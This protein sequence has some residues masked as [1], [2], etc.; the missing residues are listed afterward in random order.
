GFSGRMFDAQLPAFRD[1]FRC[2]TIDLRGH[3]QSELTPSGY[4][5]ET[6]SDDVAALIEQLGAA[7]CHF[8][9][10]SV[11]GFI[12]LRLAARRPQLLRSLVLIGAA[13]LDKADM[14]L[15]F[16]LTPILARVLGTRAISGQYLKVMFT[17]EFLRDPAHRADVARERQR[18]VANRRLGVA[19]LADGV[20]AQRTLGDE[21]AKIAVPVL[22]I[23]G[24]RDLLVSQAAAQRTMSRI[25]G[26]RSVAIPESAH[27]CNIETPAAVNAALRGF[28]AA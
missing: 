21:L 7:P 22:M 12:G 11:G 19:R 25:K 16:K 1:R 24:A 23:N 17:P 6:L 28:L 2:I 9:G 20:I 15:G 26:G 3:G 18:F 5:M 27:A 8:V 4:D 14:D 13:D 10:W